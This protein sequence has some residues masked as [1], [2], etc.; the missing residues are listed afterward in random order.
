MVAN[1]FDPGGGGVGG[2]G[3]GRRGAEAGAEASLDGLLS[4]G[5]VA[6]KKNCLE[7][8]KKRGGERFEICRDNKE[9]W[10]QTE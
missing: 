1:A 2:G 9:D 4:Q 5:R 7:K 3:R 10:K 8:K 6:Q